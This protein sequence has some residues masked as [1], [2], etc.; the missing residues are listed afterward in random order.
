MIDR[1]ALSDPAQIDAHPFSLQ[2]R[3]ACPVIDFQIM[4]VDQRQA[5]EHLAAIRDDGVLVLIV[6]LPQARQDAKRHVERPTGPVADLMRDGERLPDVRA[7]RH[8]MI[9]SGRIQSQDVT[10]RATRSS[11]L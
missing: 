2:K 3:G 11:G 4:I 1:V 7:H 10:P 9:S 6:E 8:G 5:L